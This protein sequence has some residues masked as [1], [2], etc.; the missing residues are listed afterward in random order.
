MA[1]VTGLAVLLVGL[2]Y[3]ELL[4][5]SFD[6]AFARAAGFPV[7]IINYALTLLLAFSV[8]VA[9]RAV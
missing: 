4:V 3:K 7:N 1:V 8:V 5:T 2:F 9:L 6:A